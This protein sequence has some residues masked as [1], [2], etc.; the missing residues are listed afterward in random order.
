VGAEREGA[1]RVS[2]L[3]REDGR[4][5]AWTVDLGTL[6]RPANADHGHGA[7][8]AAG[9][10]ASGY[11]RS[12]GEQQVYQ[13][14]PAIAVQ[15]VYP[16]YITSAT[17]IRWWF[18]ERGGGA[19]NRPVFW[20]VGAARGFR[21]HVNVRLRPVFVSRASCLVTS[22]AQCSGIPAPADHPEHPAPAGALGCAA[23]PNGARMCAMSGA[24]RWPPRREAFNRGQQAFQHRSTGPRRPPQLK[25]R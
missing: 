9:A 12:D 4:E 25:T 5:P 23:S 13:Q 15:P 18:M 3:A 17:T 1:G 7:G 14:G 11:L 16:Q 20:R 24:S 6:P 19:R 22:L 8:P 2:G 10:Q 21:H